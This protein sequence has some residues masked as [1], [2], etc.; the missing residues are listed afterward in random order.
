MFIFNSLLGLFGYK[1]LYNLFKIYNKNINSYIIS[2][3]NSIFTFSISLLNLYHKL[4]N[5]KWN[6]LIGFTQGYL[7]FD[8]FLSFKEKN[9]AMIVH[10]LFMSLTL[11]SPQ[12]I[13]YI[14]IDIPNLNYILSRIYICEFSNV[15][16]HTTV[17]LYKLGKTN[18]KYF[19]L[20]KMLTLLSYITLRVYNFTWIEYYLFIKKY[21]ICF[22]LMLPVTFLNYYWFL[23][24]LM[25]RT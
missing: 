4:D 14:N 11:F 24:L 5:S 20:L 3:I 1:R 25:K 2:I 7:Y 21:Y 9:I 16:L 17:I 6:S 19:T 12:Y 13:D 22:Y 23:K 8:L 18:N 15:F 10:H